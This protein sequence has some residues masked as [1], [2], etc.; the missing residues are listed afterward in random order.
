VVFTGVECVYHAN[1]TE[2]CV[3]GKMQRA[4]M[5]QVVYIV[6]TGRLIC[7]FQR[8][9]F[10]VNELEKGKVRVCVCNLLNKYRVLQHY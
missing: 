1:N 9:L 10:C 3:C 8:K 7:I 2:H 6:T 4:L 5:Y